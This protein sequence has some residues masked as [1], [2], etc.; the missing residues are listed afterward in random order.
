[1]ITDLIKSYETDPQSTKEMAENL[2]FSK[3]SNQAELAAWT[4]TVNSLYNLDIS[5]NRE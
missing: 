2:G 3:A 1:L 5:K 4:M